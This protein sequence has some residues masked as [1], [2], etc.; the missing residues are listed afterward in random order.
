ME[1]TA[2]SAQIT[3]ILFKPHAY[4]MDTMR[5]NTRIGSILFQTK[6]YPMDALRKTP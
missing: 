3:L 6:T 5:K 4:P 2:R 1:G